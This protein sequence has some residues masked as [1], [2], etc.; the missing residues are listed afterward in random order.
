M[1]RGAIAPNSGT[2]STSGVF[3]VAAPALISDSSAVVV[4]SLVSEAK[5]WRRFGRDRQGLIVRVEPAP[6][7]ID[8]ALAV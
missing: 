1:P 5:S 4:N 7:A 8:D 2:I 3:T 6:R